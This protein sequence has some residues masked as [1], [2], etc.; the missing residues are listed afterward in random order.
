MVS[1]APAS[2]PNRRLNSW[3]QSYL[4]YTNGSRGP[5]LFRKW[6]AITILAA[7]LERRCWITTDD[8]RLNPNLYTILIGR[9]GV[10]KG[11]SISPAVDIYRGTRADDISVKPLFALAPKD[12]TKEA[13][14][15]YLASPEARRRRVFSGVEEEYNAALLAVPEFG[16]LIG[17]YNDKLLNFLNEVFDST[18]PYRESR[19]GR[20]REASDQVVYI[21]RPIISLLAGT[22]PAYIASAFPPSAWD[23]GFMARTIMVYTSEVVHK[24]IFS[25]RKQDEELRHALSWDIRQLSLLSG[26]FQFSPDAVHMLETWF[27][28]GMPPRPTHHRLHH[29]NTRRHVHLLKL[30]MVASVDRGNDLRIEVS[31]FEQARDFL[32]EVETLMPDVFMEMSGRSDEHVL[33]QLHWYSWNLYAKTRTPISRALLLQYLSTMVPSYQVQPIL[34][35]AERSDLLEREAGSDQFIPRPKGLR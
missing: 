2:R 5:V 23:Q 4:D 28:A 8:G 10:G 22:T 13:L 9:P 24:P 30:C 21:P 25:G 32:L 31:D 15:D 12:A 11:V 27:A 14:V 1:L 19:R 34:E 16:S 18:E 35:L 26:E 20:S 33:K 29:Y 3:I 17:D 6:T 7:A